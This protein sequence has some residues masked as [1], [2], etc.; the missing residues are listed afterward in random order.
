[1]A[2]SGGIKNSKYKGKYKTKEEEERKSNESVKLKR[3]SNRKVKN[4]LVNSN[5]TLSN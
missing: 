1:M 4:A 5:T 3:G 2:T